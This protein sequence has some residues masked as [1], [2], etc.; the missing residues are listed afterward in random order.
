METKLNS[1]YVY[2]LVK[3]RHKK[4]ML[5]ACPTRMPNYIHTSHAQKHAANV[6]EHINTNEN[7]REIVDYKITT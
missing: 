1:R 2:Y 5:H 4:A 7:Y 3:G 6:Y